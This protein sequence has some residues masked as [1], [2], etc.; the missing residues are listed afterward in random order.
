M[1]IFITNILWQN[2]ID[3]AD[4]ICFTSNGV[5]KKN[6]RLVM[7]AG[8]AKAFRD[9]FLNL[10]WQAAQSVKEHGNIC[11]IVGAARKSQQSKYAEIVAFPT[12]HHWKDNSDIKLI[13]QSITQLVELADHMKWKKI[14]LPAPGVSN[15][16]LSWK[17]EVEPLLMKKLD[18]RFI[19]TFLQKG[20]T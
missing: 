12:K 17:K 5:I 19:I 14:Y 15:G 9:K 18:D 16:G 10:D 3:D 7:G 20:R 6:G 1:K 11:Q 13:E 4:A 8:V 2:V